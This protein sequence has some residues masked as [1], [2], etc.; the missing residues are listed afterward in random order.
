MNVS[1]IIPV[2]NEERSIEPVL[3]KVVSVAQGME[4]VVVDDGSVDGTPGILQR[5]SR[6]LPIRVVTHPHNRGKGAAIHTALSS[7]R[8]EIVLIQDA[9]FE[10]DPEEY[11]ILLKPLQQ[12]R[13]A[14]VYGSRF[15]GSHQA[16]YFWHR[17]GNWVITNVVNL[18]FNASL[19]D[20]ETGYKAFRR[21]VL[22]GV[23]LRARSF[24]FEVEFT[25]KLLRAGRAMFEVP[26]S[27]YGRT[28]AEGKKITWRDG[29][30]ALATILRF[31]IDP[32]Y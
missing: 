19:T 27:Y 11:P 16:I 24:D 10:Y 3:R 30:T 22:D 9:D 1:I 21:D 14:V 2:Y 6:E 17:L 26:I 8:G 4:I 29:L 32:S 23:T 13:V 31:R 15:L 12:G 28:Y 20:V 18:L 7:V 25:C 5:L